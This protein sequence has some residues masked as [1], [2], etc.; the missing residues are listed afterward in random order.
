VFVCRNHNSIAVVDAD[1]LGHMTD[2][3]VLDLGHN[4]IKRLGNGSFAA[5]LSSLQHLYVHLSVHLFVTLL[6]NFLVLFLLFRTVLIH[7]V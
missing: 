6:C 2:L 1:S 4:R 5:G 3:E 7:F